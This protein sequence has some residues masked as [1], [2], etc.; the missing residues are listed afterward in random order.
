MAKY[1]AAGTRRPKASPR[2]ALP[3]LFLL[4]IG[5]ALVFL[6]FYFGMQSGK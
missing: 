6:L 2:S 3:C 1:K 5:F 4:V